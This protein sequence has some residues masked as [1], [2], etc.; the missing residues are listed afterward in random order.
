M[1][2]VIVTTREGETHTVGAPI[3]V[4]VMEAIRDGG[5]DELLALCGGGC[6][7]ATCHVYVDPTSAETIPPIS[8]DENDLLDSSSHRTD[9]SRLSCQIRLDDS[10]S[11][12]RVT[13]APED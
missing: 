8:E 2:E 6:A 13:V 3:G 1:P 7:C 5:V 12:L 4:S 11:G 10:L 9:R